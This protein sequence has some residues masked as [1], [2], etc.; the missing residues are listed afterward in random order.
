MMHRPACQKPAGLLSDAPLTPITAMQ[1]TMRGQRSRRWGF[2]IVRS[3]SVRSGAENLK[4]VKVVAAR[5]VALIEA[6]VLRLR[7]GAAAAWRRCAPWRPHAITAGKWLAGA[8][9]ILYV[10]TAAT[11]YV[12]Q[13]SLLYFP[14]TVHTTP[15]QAGL[16]QAEEV[17]LTAADGVPSL[18]WHVPPGENKPVILYFHGNGGALRYRATRFRKLVSD[19]IGLVGLEYRGFGGLAGEPT[20]AGLIADAQAAYD[21]AVT[22]YPVQQIVVWGESLGSGVA[23]ALAAQQP[24]GRLILEAPFTSIEAIGAMRYWYM[25]VWLLMKDQYHSDERIAKVTAPVLILHGARDSVVPY[26]MGEQLF[27]LTKAQKHIVR[28]LDGSHEDLDQYGALHAVGRFLAGDLD[29]TPA[30]RSP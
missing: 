26:A 22:R 30:R 10:G 15:A 18:V 8:A 12:T 27:D 23:V 25:P 5:A 17:K 4:E 11:L 13:R 3:L 29:Q 14:E 21:F 7:D 9:L 28:F 19:G 1:I 6:L 20:E 24:V 2:L 16:P